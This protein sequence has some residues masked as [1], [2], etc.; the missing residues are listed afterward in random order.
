[1]DYPFLEEFSND[2]GIAQENLVEA[3]KIEKEFHTRILEEKNPSVRKELY[4]EVYNKVHVIYN[5]GKTNEFVNKNRIINLFRKELTGKSIID[6]GC[7]KGDFLISLRETIPTKKL[8]GLDVSEP[9]LP[10]EY[11]NIEF[12]NSDIIEFNTPEKFDIVFSDNVM[13]HIA[14]AD[15]D[16]HLK[17]LYNTLNQYGKLII[18][19]PNKLFGPSD[20]T[21]II[22]YTYSNKTEAM[23]THLNEST[24]TDMIKLLKSK[25]FR[26]I[27]TIIPIPKLKF[28]FSGARINASIVSLL[29]NP[30]FIN[31]L[32][33]IKIK[34]RCIYRLDVVLICSK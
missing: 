18:I 17:C 16:T 31:I 34:G 29:E 2:I 12:I 3:F 22:D 10:K 26:K 27:R 19:M 32:Y 21:R 33:K 23:G 8:V 7:G 6:I 11:G 24:Y 25:N 4:K 13:E 9:M 1:M 20:V 28:I 15:L 5:R 14:P 30:F